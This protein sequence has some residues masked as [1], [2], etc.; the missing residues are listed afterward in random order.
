MKKFSVALFTLFF[1][2]QVHAL[3]IV[4]LQD[5]YG[6]SIRTYRDY[7]CREAQKACG[8]DRRISG[9]TDAQCVV[10]YDDADRPIPNPNPY[11]NPNPN[12]FPNPNPNPFPNP[13]PNPY[14]GQDWQRMSVIDQAANFIFEGCYV[15]KD[16]SGWANQLFVRNVF[17]GNFD[18]NHGD[19]ELSRRLEDLI[20][21]RTCVYKSQ[22]EINLMFS[23][24]LIFDFANG[25][26][27]RNCYVKTR[28]PGNGGYYNQIYVN[29]VFRGN[30][31]EYQD[32][33]LLRSELARIV[34]NGTCR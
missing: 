29:G 17:S 12:P 14:P 8:Y 19:Y 3:C 10:V 28:V 27:Y 34:M 13:N 31:L 21:N 16:V 18:T 22:Q 33:K 9:R 32:D 6:R 2:A 23:P 24:N 26:R 11:P 5:Y 25:N 7:V 1:T 15:L 30:Y 4:E 20:Y